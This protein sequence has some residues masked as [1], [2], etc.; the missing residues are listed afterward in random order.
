VNAFL[1]RENREQTNRN[2]VRIEQKLAKV[3]NL[4]TLIGQKS[5][6]P[7]RAPKEAKAGQGRAVTRPRVSADDPMPIAALTDGTEGRVNARAAK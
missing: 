2:A 1:L 5:I 3:V 6:R 4:A 7:Q